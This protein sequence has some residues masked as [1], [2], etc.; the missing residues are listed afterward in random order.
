MIDLKIPPMLRS[1]RTLVVALLLVVAAT[2]VAIAFAHPDSLLDHGMY[3]DDAFY[4][5]QIARNALEGRGLSFDASGP[6]SGFQPLYQILLVPVVAISG[7][8]PFVPVLASL[9]LL[10]AW[11][12]A[13]GALAFSLGRA[14][15]GT[16]AGLASLLLFAVSPYFIVFSANGQETGLAMFFALAVAQAHLWLFQDGVTRSRKAVVGCGVVGGFAVLARLDLAFLLAALVCDALLRAR[17]WD[18][19]LVRGRT[20]ALATAASIL[21]WLP[22]SAYSQHT[23]GNWLPLSGAASREIAL[24]LGWYEMDRVWSDAESPQ[25]FDPKQPPAVF[26]ADVLTKLGAVALMEF[27]L[28]SPLR[29]VVPFN[30]WTGVTG[31]PPYQ[32]FLRY[33]GL[34]STFAAAAGACLVVFVLRRRKGPGLGLALAVYAAL[35]A[36]GYGYA[37]PTHWYF[38]RY[39]APAL[40]LGSVAGVAAAARF[41]SRYP[42]RQR[43]AMAALAMI[44]I[45]A[46]PLRDLKFFSTLS[47][48]ADTPPSVLREPLER[49]LKLLPP[50]ARLGAF[51]A[52]MLTWF[53]G[54]HVM[55]L[56]GKVN[57]AAYRAMADGR[58]HEYVLASGVTHILAW[59]WVLVRMCLRHAPPGSLVLQRL[60]TGANSYEA[61]L[62]RIQRP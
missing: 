5:L 45:L 61:T 36:F 25:V 60:D 2:R 48:A 10:A 29:L 46:S 34:I 52:G 16:G 30:P 11:A 1:T 3:Q 50:D 47:F 7:D 31:Y 14:L 17:D 4:Y 51:Q 42:L 55:N 35:L 8:G 32:L 19:A 18:D 49:A 6:T 62:Y 43:R 37:V 22:W 39:L 21:I 23:T 59:E 26:Y 44:A 56:D 58:L 57:N 53:A 20:L 28:L 9:L 12:I 15:A 54:G 41:L 38:P 13:T 33:P 27:P 40:L 24:N